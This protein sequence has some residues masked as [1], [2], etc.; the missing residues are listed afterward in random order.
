MGAAQLLQS[1]EAEPD[2][3]AVAAE[4]PFADFHEIAYDRAGQIFHLGP[5]AGRTALRPAIEGAFL[6]A[7]WKYG[8]DLRR[9]SPE[10]AAAHSRVPILLVHGQVDRNI[11]LRHSELIRANNP[12]VTLW[13]VPGADHCGAITVAPR[14]FEDRLIRWF[15]VHSSRPAS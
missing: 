12:S 5:W 7:Q 9:V 14:Q 2:F 1:L 11:P 13:V 15:E 4:S 3:C 8:Y 10:A 6:Y